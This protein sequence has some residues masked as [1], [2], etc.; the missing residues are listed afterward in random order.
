MCVYVC[1]FL[2]SL[3]VVLCVCIHSQS[4]LCL[5][6]K[7][8]NVHWMGFPD[9]SEIPLF[10]R[11]TCPLLFPTEGPID[12]Y[13]LIIYYIVSMLSPS[14]F[15]PR[16]KAVWAEPVATSKPFQTLN[17]PTSKKNLYRGLTR[18]I[19]LCT[20]ML[21]GGGDSVIRIMYLLTYNYSNPSASPLSP[22]S[23]L[24]KPPTNSP[25]SDM[26]INPH[27]IE[28]RHTADWLLINFVWTQARPQAS[29][30]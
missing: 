30:N 23:V 7:D 28:G 26:L 13:Q 4:S 16:W 2:E 20:C 24:T 27:S 6:Y 10:V 12:I 21:G 25:S 29:S 18:P 1:I 19:C 9:L 22:Q 15:K 5:L 17:S 11:F 3:H 14:K 8:T